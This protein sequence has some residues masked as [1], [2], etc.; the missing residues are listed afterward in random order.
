MRARG[1]WCKKGMSLCLKKYSGRRVKV[2]LSQLDYQR[3]KL[4]KFNLG[5]KAAEIDT[6]VANGQHLEFLI[7]NYGKCLINVSRIDRVYVHS[8]NTDKHFPTAHSMNRT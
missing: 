8:P 6:T 1:V 4:L 5:D 3:I 2:K 7:T